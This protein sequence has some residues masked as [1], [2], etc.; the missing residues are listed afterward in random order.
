VK[1][2]YVA[3]H[4]HNKHEAVSTVFFDRVIGVVGL[5]ILSGVMVLLNWRNPALAHWGR[6]IGAVFVLFVTGAVVYFSGR[7]R[8]LFRVDALIA[9]LP[10][11]THIQRMDQAILAFRHQRGR[12]AAA[13]A[14]TVVLQAIGIFSWFLAGWAMGL[15]GPSPLQTFWVYLAYVPVCFLA[16]ALPIGVME[17]TFKELIGGAAGLGS[18]AAAVSLSLIARLI[19]LG[20]ALPGGLVVLRGGIR[21]EL[22]LPETADQRVNGC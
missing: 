14:L 11:A 5:V 8:R 16:G 4:T 6:I 3:K 12:V 2:F 15:V 20:W 9:R 22:P 17:V 7:L 13:V 10:L 18:P 19:Q 21:S 1:A